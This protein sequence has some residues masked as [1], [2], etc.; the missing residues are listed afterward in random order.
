MPKGMSQYMRDQRVELL[1]KMKGS[2]FAMTVASDFVCLSKDERAK[3]VRVLGA[4]NDTIN[5]EEGAE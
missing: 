5:R 3:A 4:L 2:D 1:R